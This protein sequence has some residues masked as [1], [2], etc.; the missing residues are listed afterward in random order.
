M[1]KVEAATGL[2]KA[3]SAILREESEA[4]ADAVLDALDALILFDPDAAK[5]EGPEEA[6]ADAGEGTADVNG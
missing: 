3:L 6:A 4:N 1:T 5:V 2:A